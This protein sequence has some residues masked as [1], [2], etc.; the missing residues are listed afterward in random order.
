MKIIGIVCM[1]IGLICSIFHAI[2][3]NTFGLLIASVAFVSGLI[4]VLIN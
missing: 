2:N 3:G 4:T 1:I